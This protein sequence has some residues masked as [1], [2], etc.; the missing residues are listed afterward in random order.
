MSLPNSRQMELEGLEL[1]IGVCR[2]ALII[3][4]FFSRRDRPQTYVQSLLQPQRR[5]RVRLYIT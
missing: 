5:T 1:P 2:T 4:L 3:D